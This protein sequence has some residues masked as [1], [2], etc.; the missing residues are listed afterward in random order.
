MPCE[1]SGC[2]YACFRDRCLYS[3]RFGNEI[4]DWSITEAQLKQIKVPTLVLIGRYD[5]AQDYVVEDFSRFIPNVTSM[6]FE[7]SS[8]TPHWDERERLMT[9]VQKFITA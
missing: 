3:I 4:K 2:P 9:A 8:H 1:C 7:E 5:L 6:T